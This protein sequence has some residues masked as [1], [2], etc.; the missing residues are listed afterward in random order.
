MQRVATQRVGGAGSSD[1]SA[2]GGGAAAENSAQKCSQGTQRSHSG[3]RHKH[4]AEASEPTDIVRA[5]RMGCHTGVS[6]DSTILL[7]MCGC[8]F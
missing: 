1:D 7:S 3:K 8:R 5:S 6:E 4:S 2:A